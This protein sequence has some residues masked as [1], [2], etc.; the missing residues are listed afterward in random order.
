MLDF[1]LQ[2]HQKNYSNIVID[3]ETWKKLLKWISS[4]INRVLGFSKM[5]AFE[6]ETKWK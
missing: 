1:Y 2:G 6:L 3:I 4:F 5:I